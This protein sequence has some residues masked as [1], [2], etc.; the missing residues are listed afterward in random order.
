MADG[1]QVQD[2]PQGI[3]HI[4]QSLPRQAGHQVRRNIGESRF[5]G[6]VIGGQ[7]IGEGVGPAQNGQ[8]PVL[9]RLTADAQPVEAHGPVGAELGVQGRG[10]I[11]LDGLF[12]GVAPGVEM[13]FFSQGG[14]DLLNPLRRHEGR[15]AAAE[16]HCG[17]FPHPSVGTGGDLRQQG[18]KI[19]GDGRLPRGRSRGEIAVGALAHA[20]G[21][22]DVQFQSCH[23]FSF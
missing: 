2:G 12:Q 1:R 9:G 6:V 21:D 15:G 17:H 11:D 4:R 3:I 20:E 16:V 13:E 23:G 10:R 7:E 18:V 19:G 22:V 5:H 8:Q 14:Q